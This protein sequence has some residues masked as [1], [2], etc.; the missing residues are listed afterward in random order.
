M[1]KEFIYV[2]KNKVVFFITLQ[3]Y[4]I[5]EKEI[6]GDKRN[7]QIFE[8]F[9]MIQK[10]SEDDLDAIQKTI[11]AAQTKFKSIKIISQTATN[12]TPEIFI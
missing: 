4:R 7:V 10:N 2:N 12:L 6:E 5:E 3:L 1:A 11:L 8:C 9:Q